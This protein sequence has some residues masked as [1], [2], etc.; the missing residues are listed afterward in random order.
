MK[1][2][3]LVAVMII[4][5][6]GCTKR[7]EDK[8]YLLPKDF[9]GYVLVLYDQSDGNEVQYIDGNKRLYEIPDSGVFKTKFKADYG[10]TSFPEF[11]YE[12]IEEE[13]KIPLVINAVDYS[14]NEINASLPNI[15]KRY[16]DD[17]KNEPIEYSIFFIG[18]K[19][20]IIK[21]S[22]KVNDKDIFELL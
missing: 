5:I 6:I 4:M 21:A 20:E 14:E 9:V 1:K 13:N 17:R 2:R 19:D 10:R 12:A 7:G 22:K 8:V 15:G 18:T 11:Y 16:P 3:L